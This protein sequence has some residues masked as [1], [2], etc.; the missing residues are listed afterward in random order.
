MR[1]G[2]ARYRDL[3][4]LGILILTGYYFFFWHL[5][6]P[7]LYDLD[8]GG[9]AEIAREILVLNDWLIPHLNFI[10]LL[11]KPPLLYWLT[12]ISFKSLGISEYTARLPVAL[13]TLACLIL[14][15]LLGRNIFNSLAGLLAGLIFATSAATFIFGFG[16]QLLPD[17]VFTSFLT[18]AFSVLIIGS[19]KPSRKGFLLLGYL[20]MGLAVMTKGLIGLVFPLLATGGYLVLTREYRLLRHL[21]L[22]RGCLVFLLLNLPWLLLV[23]LKS[24]GFLRFY[25]L[26]VHIL[27]FFHRGMIAS[28]G[29][30]LPL[31]AFWAV[32][33]LWFYP[34]V[35]FLP[36]AFWRHPPSP[37]GLRD[38]EDKANLW[39]WLWAGSVIVFFSLSS[40]RLDIYGLPAL[41]ALSLILGRYWSG[42]LSGEDGKRRG[43][44]ISL[45]I[46]VSSAALMLAV[47]YLPPHWRQYLSREVYGMVDTDF[48]GY[49]QGLTHDAKVVS[50]PSWSELSSIWVSGSSI[51]LIGSLMA[52]MAMTRNRPGWSFLSLILTMLP[53]CYYTQRGLIIFEP[54][55]S[56]KPLADMLLGQLQPGE[57]IVKDG[58]YEEIAT[59]TFYTGQRVYLVHGRRDDLLFGSRYPEGREA[60]L[61]EEQFLRL[62]DSPSRVYL[63]TDYPVNKQPTRDPFYAKLRLIELGHS[64]NMYLFTNKANEGTIP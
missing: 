38:L 63:L 40:F 54:Y 2:S 24:K 37:K 57:K 49:Y 44:M 25:L 59:V 4:Y 7:A 52:L 1:G 13:S 23:E 22:L 28:Y 8:E 62:W 18:A 19:L 26:D 51:L 50:L 42:V 53:I 20:A 35:V 34:W 48:R 31:P 16:R 45:T 33:A 64:G 47:P 36:L 27:R 29:A 41:P 39:L 55:K 58:R 43:L 46:L 21:D 61:T 5:G 56:S 32:T 30:S 17:M 12:A 60:F 10:R 15:F 6:S 14:C 11:D 9:Y 3:F